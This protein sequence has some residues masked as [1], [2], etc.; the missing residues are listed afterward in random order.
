ML[1]ASAAS[2]RERTRARAPACSADLFFRDDAMLGFVDV[3]KLV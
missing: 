2:D 1:H 3:K